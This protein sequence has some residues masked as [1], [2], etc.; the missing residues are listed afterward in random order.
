MLT[1]YHC[2]KLTRLISG[3][4]MVKGSAPIQMMKKG[5]GEELWREKEKL[6]LA[7]LVET[8]PTLKEPLTSDAWLGLGV[9]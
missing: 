1:P 8:L 6:A 7:W 3:D 5:L 4:N 9:K 2:A